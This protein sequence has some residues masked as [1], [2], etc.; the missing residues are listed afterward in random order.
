MSIALL[1]RPSNGR[2][3]QGPNHA[4]DRSLDGEQ[5]AGTSWR[6]SDAYYRM[7]VGAAWANRSATSTAATARALALSHR[8]V[9]RDRRLLAEY[10]AF[11]RGAASDATRRYR[12][13]LQDYPDDMDIGA[14]WRSGATATP[15]YDRASREQELASRLLEKQAG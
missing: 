1:R 13:I 9:D 12:G 5:R 14:S 3:P 11:R 2:K 8:L 10:A 4:P 6:P 7:A 15:L